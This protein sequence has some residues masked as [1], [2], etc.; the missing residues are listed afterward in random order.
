ML[1]IATAGNPNCGKSVLF[2]LLT[3]GRQ[4]VGN[5]PGVTVDKKIGRVKHRN[6]DAKLV[7]LPGIYA[8]DAWSEDERIS[9]D[10][11]LSGEP[12]FL[13]NI[14]D[15]TNLERNLYLTTIL[16]EM[17]VKMLVVLNMIDLAEKNKIG[18][19]LKQFEKELGSPVVAVSALRPGSKDIIINKIAEL[20]KTEN[21]PSPLPLPSEIE[22]A[23]EESKDELLAEWRYKRIENIMAKS[24]KKGISVY[25]QSDKIDKNSHEQIFGHTAL[26]VRNVFDVLAHNSRRRNFYRLF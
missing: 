19:D 20:L 8:L 6:L 12:E 17:G 15:S 13:L 22:N 10:Y 7:D 1:T 24:V 9:R 18:I 21:K 16:Q 26:F 3:G 14:L 5:W 23:S 25:T 11:L 2:N 4:K